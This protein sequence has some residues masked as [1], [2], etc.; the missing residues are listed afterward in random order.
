MERP[1]IGRPLLE[2][3]SRGSPS[4]KP[5]ESPKLSPIT[6]NVSPPEVDTSTPRS[7]FVYASS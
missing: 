7:N 6:L 1:K 2:V 3:G 5:S 4:V